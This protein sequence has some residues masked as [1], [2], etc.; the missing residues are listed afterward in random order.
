MSEQMDVQNSISQSR[1]L[2]RARLRFRVHK[3]LNIADG[4][5]DVNNRRS[6]RCSLRAGGHQTHHR[7][8]EWLVLST[9]GFSSEAEARKFGH[10][11]RA[12]LEVS[13][14]ANRLGV[15]P[16]RDCRRQAWVSCPPDR[17]FRTI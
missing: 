1:R 12:A 5:E 17:Y 15:D 6:G 13:S 2:Y 4:E 16:G 14:I 7:R 8:C 3:K 10:K 11:L 9:S